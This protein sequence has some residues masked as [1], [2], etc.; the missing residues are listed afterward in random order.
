MRNRP[1]YHEN[2]YNQWSVAGMIAV[3]TG[4]INPFDEHGKIYPIYRTNSGNLHYSL[5][6]QDYLR[7]LNISITEL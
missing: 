1:N 5:I 3:E 6:G 4:A 2:R 7:Q